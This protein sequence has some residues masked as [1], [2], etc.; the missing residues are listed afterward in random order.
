MNIGILSKRTNM[1]A[2]RMK[3]YFE[4]LGHIV[5]IYTADNLCIN[6]NLLKHDFF[7][8]K[9][10]R[11]IY[12]YAG[13]FIKENNV[14]I[15]PD[16]DIT[17]KHK[18][19]IEAHYLIKEA[20]LTSPKFYVGMKNT[21]KTKLNKE[22]FPIVSKSLMD[23]A[24]KNVNFINSAKEIDSLD[25]EVVYFEEKIQGTHYIIYFIDKEISVSEKPPLSTE[26]A[27]MK[28]IIPTKEMIEIV[29]KW[30][31]CHRIPFGHLDVIKEEKSGKIYVV[32]PGNFPEF[33]NWKQGDDPCPK[34]CNI[35]LKKIKK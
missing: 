1:F 21:I 17:Y 32:D 12:L 22:S 30:K 7:I 5:K 19:R 27:K 20:G 16:P 18:Y 34:I 2:G 23:S 6:K 11:I 15:F 33:S 9:S 3:A 28:E 25:D 13:Y 24:S 31:K 29:N 35:I 8:L 14:P 10:K 4:E 26:H